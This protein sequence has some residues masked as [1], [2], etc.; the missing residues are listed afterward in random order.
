MV[1]INLPV[2]AKRRKKQNLSNRHFTTT[3]FFK[4]NVNYFLECVPKDKLNVA[5][6]DFCQ[7]YP[8]AG[9]NLGQ[10]QHHLHGFFVP[11]RT[12]MDGYNDFIVNNPVGRYGSLTLDRVPEF[13]SSSASY[14]VGSG[15]LA[16]H[17]T[18]VVETVPKISVNDFFYL[19][20]RQFAGSQVGEGGLINSVLVSDSYSVPG[21]P[22]DYPLLSFDY[23]NNRY[24]FSYDVAT[25]TSAHYESMKEWDIVFNFHVSFS[26]GS[27]AE[28]RYV[29]FNLSPLGRYILSLL[30]SVG[31]Q[32][33]LSVY[34]LTDPLAASDWVLDNNIVATESHLYEYQ[35]LPILA[36]MKVFSD[37]FVPSKFR[38][39]YDIRLRDM[40]RLEY[41]F[42]IAVSRGSSG[43]S[44]GLVTPLF[45]ED[46]LNYTMYPNDYFTNAFLYPTGSNDGESTGINIPDITLTNDFNSNF[47]AVVSQPIVED[48][49]FNTPHS[50]ASTN[51]MPLTQYGLR[52]LRALTNYVVRNRIAGYRSI[53]RFMAQFGQKL[54]YTQTNRSVLIKSNLEEFF[55]NVVVS[56]TDSHDSSVQPTPESQQALLGGRAANLVFGGS[57]KLD[58]EV[59]EPGLF[60]VISSVNPK[61][62][63]VE[64]I[65]RMYLHL[66]FDDFYQPSFDSLGVQA[67]LKDELTTKLIPSGTNYSGTIFGYSPRYAEYKTKLDR[68]TGD[69][70]LDNRNTFLE[71]LHTFRMFDSIPDSIN[72]RFLIGESSVFDRIFQ[73][74]TDEYDHFQLA[75]YN[76][77]VVMR[78]TDTMSDAE[79]ITDGNGNYIQMSIG[80]NHQL[81]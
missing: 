6:R 64:G 3:D 47:S 63:Y 51:S 52:A 8:L 50:D 44:V 28:N 14:F 55:P 29:G 25:V 20:T 71:S 33:H 68:L 74:T 38:T 11:F 73:F 77:V 32:P 78:P 24:E 65:D 17:Q 26:D 34:V 62:G 27:S 76:D 21:T 70:A 2:A 58:Y 37:W 60:L 57:L 19:L 13:Y 1:K 79:E 31:F 4:A 49:R 56:Q 12:L 30:R 40:G 35:A 48:E 59:S 81:R 16:D 7:G 9:A 23:V 36:L 67:I 10:F 69:F 75:S 46:V 5:I 45:L 39:D 22:S 54:D 18:R 41:P 72:Q 53:D 66:K 15:D 43:S 80:G 61:V 42:R